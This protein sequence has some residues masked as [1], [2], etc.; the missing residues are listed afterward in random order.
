MQ[1]AWRQTARSAEPPG[2]T[3]PRR[4]QGRAPR[5]AGTQA[6]TRV[7]AMQGLEALRQHDRERGADEQARAE[8]GH[9]AQLGLRHSEHAGQQPGAQRACAPRTS[10]VEARPGPRYAVDARPLGA[11]V[12]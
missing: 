2:Q 11:G 9:R 8:R 6:R 12:G 4:A 5:R 7:R 3:E 1:C 10:G